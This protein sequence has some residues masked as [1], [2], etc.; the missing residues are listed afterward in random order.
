MAAHSD[1]PQGYALFPLSP[2]DKIPLKG[3]RGF[4]DA[5]R[6]PDTLLRWWTEHPDANIGLP[7]GSVNGLFVVD[8]DPRKQGSDE[9]ALLAALHGEPVTRRVR[10]PSGGQHLY[11]RWPAAGG[12][13]NGANV[14]RGIDV[15]G[16]GGYVVAPPSR[17]RE[18]RDPRN[19]EKIV[20]AAG[21]YT[22][23]DHAPIAD[24]P[25]WILERVTK[26]EPKRVMRVPSSGIP[27]IHEGERNER[28]FRIARGARADG[29]SEAQ[30]LERLRQLNRDGTV[31]VPVDDDELRLIARQGARVSPGREGHPDTVRES[32]EYNLTDLGNAQRLA[33]H[34]AGLIH[35]LTDRQ[36]WAVWDGRR[37]KRDSGELVMR[38]AQQ[39]VGDMYRDAANC[40]DIEH[41]KT[42]AAHARSCEREGRLRAMVSLAR[43]QSAVMTDSSTFD[44]QPDLL[45]VRNGTLDLSC[46]ELGPHDRTHRITR[47]VDLAYDFNAGCPTW[48]AFLERVMDGNRALIEYLRRA[49]GYSLTGHTREHCL[50]LLHGTG[51]NGKSTFT[52]TVSD[53]LGEYAMRTQF[54]T[55]LASE[56]GE[57]THEIAALAGARL[58]VSNEAESS[59]RFAESLVKQATG[60]DRMRGCF[61]YQNSF[62]FVPTFK[63]WLALNHKPSVR[64]T[65]EGFWRRI[66]LVPFGVTI[67]PEER[68]PT[69]RDRLREELPGILAWAVRGAFEWYQ[70]GLSDP[71]EVRQATADYRSDQDFLAD[72]LTMCVETSPGSEEI[73]GIG[74]KGSAVYKSFRAWCE[75]QGVRPMSNN[76]LAK[77]LKDRGYK[78]RKNSSGQSEWVGIRVRYGGTEA[79]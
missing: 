22:V 9:W 36:A 65:D 30:I 71:E 21:E 75:A 47:A 34:H 23:I 16:E 43:S 46:G 51:A 14:W 74:E 33:D 39:T 8:I 17:T 6:E 69:L 68:D 78:S 7:T 45:T 63:L 31:L 27:P 41:R 77:L 73:L 37:F 5:S 53:V 52:E 79:Q 4:K 72:W 42:L 50:F 57:S 1:L 60:G 19:P 15:R 11:F 61:K 62:E 64:G 49:V 25:A 32:R 35:W 3:S 13:P 70:Y 54:S 76:T 20:T 29:Y 18:R 2:G 38:A 66:R 48:E 12:V 28:L 10:T 26:A 59:A 58:V 44:V 67:P 56:R 24:A 55:W 40:E